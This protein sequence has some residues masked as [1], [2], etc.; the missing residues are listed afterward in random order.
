MQPGWSLVLPGVGFS[1]GDTG[2]MMMNEII[3]LV[4]EILPDEFEGGGGVMVG[5][6]FNNLLI[7]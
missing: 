7:A 2:L 6:A 4:Y 1:Q 5:E 3:S